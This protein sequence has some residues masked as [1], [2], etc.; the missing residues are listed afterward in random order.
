M[1]SDLQWLGIQVSHIAVHFV[2][3]WSKYNVTFTFNTWFFTQYQSLVKLGKINLNRK[4]LT[5]FWVHNNLMK[6]L[7]KISHIMA[8]L[9]WSKLHGRMKNDNI[10]LM[11]N[12]NFVNTIHNTHLYDYWLIIKAYKISNFQFEHRVCTY[13]FIAS[14]YFREPNKITPTNA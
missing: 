4:A 6:S 9:S 13:L 1:F 10:F 11:H 7:I 14:P 2:A 3:P 5:F 12:F 8:K